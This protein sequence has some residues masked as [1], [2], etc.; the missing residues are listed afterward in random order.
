MVERTYLYTYCLQGSTCRAPARYNMKRHGDRHG[1][2]ED[3]A[4]VN[5]RR[6]MR[7]LMVDESRL[8]CSRV[9]KHT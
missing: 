9:N 5:S 6:E 1:T 4:L 2:V 3:L 8:N 7:C